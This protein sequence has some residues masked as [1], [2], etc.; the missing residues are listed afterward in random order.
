[1]FVQRFECFQVIALCSLSLLSC[2]PHLATNF[3]S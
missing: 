3:P 2:A 1:M